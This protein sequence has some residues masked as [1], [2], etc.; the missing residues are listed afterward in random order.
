MLTSRHPQ[1]SVSFTKWL[2]T[3]LCLNLQRLSPV[4][5]TTSSYRK[6]LLLMNHSSLHPV[7]CSYVDPWTWGLLRR[8]QPGGWWTPSSLYSFPCCWKAGLGFS[9]LSFFSI[10]LPVGTIGLL[11]FLLLSSCLYSKHNYLKTPW[12]TFDYI[13]AVNCIGSPTKFICWSQTSNMTV[14]EIRNLHKG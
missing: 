8:L 1:D 13:V 9:D 7:P 14:L 6:K 12:T 4:E 11:V 3:S 5:T 10:L 2:L